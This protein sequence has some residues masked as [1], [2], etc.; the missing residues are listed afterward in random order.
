MQPTHSTEKISLF[1]KS[2]E[3]GV[4][5]FIFF[6]AKEGYTVAQGLINWAK[7]KGGV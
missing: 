1:I 2:I 4:L 3:K 5:N 6:G 7:S